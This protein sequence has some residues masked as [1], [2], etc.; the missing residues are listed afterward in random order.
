[1]SKSY[2]FKKKFGNKKLKNDLP[3]LDSD[4]DF[5]AA[6]LSN[7]K[8]GSSEKKQEAKRPGQSSGK[9][10]HGLPFIEDYEAQFLEDKNKPKQPAEQPWN[11]QSDQPGEEPETDEDFALLL[12]QS[13]KQRKLVPKAPRPMPL[14]KRLKRYPAPEA[15]LD[16]HGFTALGAQMKAKSFI[17]SAKYQGFFTLRIIVGKG[18]HSEEGPVLP[19]VIEDLLKA[20]KKENTILAYKWEQRKKEKSGAVI[21]Y[22][23]QFQE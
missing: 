2:K 13:L 6:F 3:V 16:L 17:A 8:T 10:K 14:K 12:D 18:L 7:K 11:D 19:H 1:M 15:D 23:K 21:V 20:L 5:I 9:N 4:Q 22:I